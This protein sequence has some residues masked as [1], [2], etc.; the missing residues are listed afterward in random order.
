MSKLKPKKTIT[1]D[2]FLK[3]HITDHRTASTHTK[4]GSKTLGIEG[5]S[6]NI[7]DEDINEFY[8]IYKKHVIEEGNDSFITEKQ[9]NEGPI[10]M[11]IDLRYG[12]DIT[13]RQHTDE[14]IYKLIRCILDGI[15]NIMIVPE[16][17]L[18]K[19]YI[20]EKKNTNIKNNFTNDKN[21]IKDGI[22][23]QIDLKMDINTKMVLRKYLLKEI[24][25]IW[26]DIPIQ[27]SWNHV[28]DE[29]VMKG[30][31]NWLLYGSKKPGDEP[32][33][34]KY[35]LNCSYDTEWKIQEQIFNDEW[36]LFNFKELTVRNS[37]LVELQ[38]K[39]I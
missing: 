24:P 26:N 6:F 20:F 15:N 39:Q 27:N 21:I 38:L 23:I 16:N 8:N 14:H 18:L 31:S 9:L 35:I 1:L 10:V 30:Y 13:I 11:D 34:L 5:G 19:C 22:H 4:I 7:P 29:C 32:Y 33:E 37:N 12:L 25:N 3:T 28:L 36:I 2:K 17:T